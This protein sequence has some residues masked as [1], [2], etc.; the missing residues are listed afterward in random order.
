MQYISV[1]DV[2]K[3]LHNLDARFGT[4]KTGNVLAQVA[5]LAADELMACAVDEDEIRRPRGAI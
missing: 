3:A 4:D 2:F 5:E 1:D